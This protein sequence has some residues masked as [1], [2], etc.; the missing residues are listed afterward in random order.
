M[1]KVHGWMASYRTAPRAW[2]TKASAKKLP[3][4]WLLELCEEMK[5]VV[6]TGLP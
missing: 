6:L 2:S 3:K 5:H 4:K 1:E